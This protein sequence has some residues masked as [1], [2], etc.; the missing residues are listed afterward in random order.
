MLKFA[1]Q[2]SAYK[3]YPFLRDR[4]VKYELHYVGDASGIHGPGW[5]AVS[6]RFYFRHRRRAFAEFACIFNFE[7]Y[8]VDK[9]RLYEY[10]E[11][12]IKFLSECSGE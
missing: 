4:S 10:D 6:L 2:E 12:T 1:T 9:C 7:G 3:L 5:L 11:K 8:R